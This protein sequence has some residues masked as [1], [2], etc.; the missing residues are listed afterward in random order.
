MKNE[1]LCFLD[2]APPANVFKNRLFVDILNLPRSPRNSGET[3][4]KLRREAMVKTEFWQRKK[5]HPLLGQL[6]GSS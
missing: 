1:P 3:L 4:T 6:L 5:S 2:V